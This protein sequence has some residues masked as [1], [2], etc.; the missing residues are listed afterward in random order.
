MSLRVVMLGDVVG[1][2]GVRAVAQLIPTIRR[3][4][5]PHL[6]IANAENA[7]GGSGL[8]PTLYKQLGID[9]TG[10]GRKPKFDR[11]TMQTNVP[12]VYVAG[13]GSEGTQIGRVKIFIE[14]AHVHVD[15]IVADLTGAAP[16]DDGRDAPFDMP[17]S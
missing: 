13:T 2:C 11:K 14:N 10:E 8:T 16:P 15:R 3:R 4:W 17:E 1:T 6:I 5:Q 7:A 9:L 12:G